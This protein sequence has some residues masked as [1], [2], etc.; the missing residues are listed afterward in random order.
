MEKEKNMF[1]Q[2]IKY[3]IYMEKKR[4]KQKNMILEV[5][6]YLKENI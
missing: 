5:K 4:E 2:K 3:Y 1:I 6:Y